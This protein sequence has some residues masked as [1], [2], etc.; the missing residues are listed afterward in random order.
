MIRAELYE[1]V[2][3]LIVL[4][5]TIIVA[6]KYSYYPQKR[7]FNNCEENPLVSIILC[8]LLILFI[9]TRPVSF[10]FSDMAGYYYHWDDWDRAAFGPYR[11]SW[12]EQNIIF[13]NLR[14][15][16][17]SQQVPVEVFFMLISLIYFGAMWWAC[18]RIFPKDSLFAFLVC[19]AAFSTFSY[20]TNGIKAGS[21]ASVF[22]LALAFSEKKYISYLLA[23]VSVGFHHSMIVV[24]VCYVIVSIY[25]NPKFFIT[26]WL[27]CLILAIAHVTYFQSMFNSIVDDQGQMYLSKQLFGKGLRVDFIFY[28][29]IPIVIGCY[30]VFKKRINSKRYNLLLNLYLLTNSVWLLCMYAEFTNRIAYLS[31]FMY[32]IVL[33]YPFLKEQWGNNQ[34][35]FAGRI[36]LAHIAFTMFMAFIYY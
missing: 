3:L 23:F 9:G 14:V 24:A 11:F 32:P 29:A 27:I 20:G 33:I 28:S 1:T 10:V 7:L 18:R 36:S 6:F 4:F 30:A 26:L 21:A 17:S 35:K 34:Y 8:V 31:W 25:K 5:A 2:Y 13:D 15:F 12:D 19:L 22:L 16:L